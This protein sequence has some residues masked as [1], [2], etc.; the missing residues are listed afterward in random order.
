M[1]IV[2]VGHVD[3]GKSTLV[4]RLL[5]DTNSL[6]EGKLE[7]VREE[8][9]RTAK[10]FEYA[11]L[12]DALKDEQEQ[13]ITIDTART[14]FKSKKREY[15]IIDAPGH[16]EFLK[17]MV[18]GAARAEAALLVIDAQEGIQENSKRHGYLLSMLGIRQVAVCVN[19]M[20]LVGYQKN[21]FDEIER[22][23]RKFLKEINLVPKAFI[24]VAAREGENLI[25]SS[26]HLAWFKGP[27]VLEALDSFEKAPSIE[28]KPF[29]MP[30]QAIYKFTEM[31]DARRIVAGRVE[32]G[33]IAVGDR[34]VFCPSN[35]HSFIKSIEG[36]N[37]PPRIQVSAGRSAGFTLSEQ[38]YIRRGDMMCKSGQ[39]LPH[40]SSL[41]RVEI[42]WMGK[43][44]M[45][46]DRPY[47]LKI[48]T[49]Q[50]TARLK[51][52]DRVIDASNLKKISKREI[53]RYDV[54]QVVLQL[55]S[56]IAFDQIGELETTGRF[57][58]VDE[59]DIAG[60]GIIRE[61]IDDGQ[62]DLRRQVAQREL[63]WDFSGVDPEERADR[64]RHFPAF[65]L[66]SGPVGMDKKTIAR[67]L[68]SQ[69]FARRAAAYFLG[70]GNL[71]RGLNTDV[72]QHR[73]ERHEH[74]RRIG[75]VAHLFM[76]A[77]LIVIATAS[78]LNDGELAHLQEVTSREGMVVV[79]VGHNKFK[80]KTADLDLDPK[81]SPA[82]NASRIMQLLVDRKVLA[83]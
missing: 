15:I 13:G 8:C 58:I 54:A 76:D 68:E 37:A 33:S 41:I 67:E 42:F 45:V 77:G 23:Y 49:D 55:V 17:N 51:S 44:P 1:N 65:V 28:E 34:V 7:R 6:P 57:V 48:G 12:L 56:P 35:K 29:R 59:Y 19:K 39:S 25:H 69:L 21:V 66:L 70:M 75:E 73:L 38:I 71:L 43:R 14:F 27:T 11:F 64:Y 80:E 52:I 22:T 9:R 61:A 40:I 5:A 2:I 24:P 74:V 46:L 63:K 79:N 60:G 62:E 16:I 18:S 4:G 3:H 10:P 32:S 78:N 53:G 50:V 82:Q 36:F 47:K 83:Q 30:V 72:E 31:E 81:I 20:D 26:S